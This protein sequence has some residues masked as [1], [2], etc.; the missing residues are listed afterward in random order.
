MKRGLKDFLSMTAAMTMEVTTATP[1]KRGLK[2]DDPN[3]YKVAHTQL[4]PLP[5]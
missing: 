5:R 2:D 3:F 1:M 4:Q